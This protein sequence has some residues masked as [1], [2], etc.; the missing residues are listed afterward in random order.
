MPAGTLL[1]HCRV[2]REMATETESETET[3]RAVGEAEPQEVESFFNE[4][5]LKPVP[6]ISTRRVWCMAKTAV[7]HDARPIHVVTE[8]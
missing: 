5:G 1:R 7:E 8:G 2:A 6:A 3:E 4:L